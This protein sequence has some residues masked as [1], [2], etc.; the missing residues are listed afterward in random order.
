MTKQEIN[1]I[2]SSEVN[3]DDATPVM[4]QYLE[5]KRE[6]QDVILLYRLGDFYETFFEDALTMSKVLE[7]TL[8]GKDCGQVIGRVPLAGIPA[9]AIDGY[10]EKL[11]NNNYK[12]A[13]CEQ[14]EDPKSAT[15]LVKR[16]VTRIVTTGTLTEGKLL[17]K[18]KNNYICSM[19]FY[20]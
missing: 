9:K 17:Q 20:L 7:I 15:G 10:L 4:K 11:I 1:Y 8:T 14:L 6:H 12:V 5:I 19:V 3:I 18:D 16:G 2:K 13:I